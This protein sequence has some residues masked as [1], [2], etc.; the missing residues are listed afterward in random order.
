MRF[1]RSKNVPVGD[2]GFGFEFNKQMIAFDEA[3]QRVFTANQLSNS[4]S[5]IDLNNANT[6]TNVPL[7]TFWW[8]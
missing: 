4:V 3:G 7:P 6:V 1:F 8:R 5:I 2:I